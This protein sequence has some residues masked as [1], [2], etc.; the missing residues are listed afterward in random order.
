MVDVDPANSSKSKE[1]KMKIIFDK[2]DINKDEHLGITE[3]LGW[4]MAIEPTLNN[5][6]QRVPSFL[7]IYMDTYPSFLIDSKGLSY[8]GF[9][10]IYA[11]G[12]RNLHHDFNTIN[13]P[14]L[15]IQT[16]IQHQVAS[17]QACPVVG[18]QAQQ[19]QQC[20]LQPYQLICFIKNLW[21]GGISSTVQV[22]SCKTT[23]QQE[24]AEEGIV[25]TVMYDGP[26]PELAARLEKEILETNPGVKWDDIAGLC[27]AKR[28]LQEA[29]VLPLL[30]P[31]YFQGIR[32]P[33]RG[34]LM[35]GPPG[36]GK[37]LLAKVVATECGTTF[38]NISCSS[39]SGEWYRD[40][41]SATEHEAS[42]RVKA[43]LLVQ[44]DGLN[45]SNNTSGKMVTVLAATN[46][47][48]S[49]DEALR[50]QLEKRIYIP[51]P[52]FK[53]RKELIKINLKSIKLAPE[54]DIDQVARRTEGYSG[55][56]LTNICRD[57]SFNGMRRKISGKTTDEIK[58]ISKS[59][60][61]NIP[62]TMDDLLE[63]LDKIKPTLSAGDIQRYEK[64]H[65]E[66][67]SS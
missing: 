32:R 27:E 54:L 57:A 12:L 61:L 5:D 39:L 52:D 20:M 49:L 65:S 10:L 13:T 67:G 36:T 3:L 6:L 16:P 28:I 47:P 62:V 58:N 8:T 35:F 19:Q 56:D 37:T 44:I 43:E 24:N 25:S 14:S 48:E 45:N 33:W 21:E 59:E 2:F 22:S 34:V 41:E 55:D 42:R 66:F 11:D 40:S 50:R 30:M 7:K 23:A 60:I 4:I 53:S 46:F 26:H 64:W 63:A 29:M 1:E 31:E 38:L 15:E 51:L 17:L 9:S 18:I